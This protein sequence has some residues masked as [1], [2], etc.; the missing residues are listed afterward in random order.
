MSWVT[1]FNMDEYAPNNM[2]RVFNE[3]LGLLALDRMV[4]SPIYHCSLPY[5]RENGIFPGNM[6]MQALQASYLSGGADIPK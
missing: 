2:V 4:T 5:I 3:L 6:G 1:G